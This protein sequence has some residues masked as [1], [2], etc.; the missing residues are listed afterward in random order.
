MISPCDNCK[1]RQKSLDP[2]GCFYQYG[3]TGICGRL[4]TMIFGCEYYRRSNDD[5]DNE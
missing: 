5:N 1:N 4:I 2:E 3:T